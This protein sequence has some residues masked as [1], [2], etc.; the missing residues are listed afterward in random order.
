VAVVVGGG[1]RADSYIVYATDVLAA[2]QGTAKYVNV[3]GRLEG[4]DYPGKEQWK[5]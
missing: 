1:D 5:D 3:S 4:T 2:H